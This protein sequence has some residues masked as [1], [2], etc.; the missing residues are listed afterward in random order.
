MAINTQGS[1]ISRS[2]QVIRQVDDFKYLVHTCSAKDINVRIGCGWAAIIKLDSLYQGLTRP[3]SSRQ[4]WKMSISTVGNPGH[5]L[6]PLRG[7]WM[8]PTHVCFG[9][10]AAK[11]QKCSPLQ[12]SPCNLYCHQR[13]QATICWSLSQSNE[14]RRP[15]Q[16]SSL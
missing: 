16:N 3:C 10:L 14:C 15:A 5:S 11:Y 8:G 7:D 4:L 12:E 6:R 9:T 2:G 13:A 1:L